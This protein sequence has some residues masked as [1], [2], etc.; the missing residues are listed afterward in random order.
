MR[1][2]EKIGVWTGLLIFIFGGILSLLV[3]FPWHAPQ[4]HVESLSLPADSEE[5]TFSEVSLKTFQGLQLSNVR[6]QITFRDGKVH[7]QCQGED[8]NT[9]YLAE[10]SYHWDEGYRP[11]GYD[12]RDGVLTVYTA[13]DLP[14]Y[15]WLTFFALIVTVAASIAL[16]LLFYAIAWVIEEVTK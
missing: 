12:Y 4:P 8:R 3:F 11:T 10:K 6:Y 14:S 1:R 5:A 2:S 16:G 9:I 13:K 15:G 7:V